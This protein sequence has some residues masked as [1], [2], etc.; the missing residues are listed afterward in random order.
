MIGRSLLLAA[1]AATLTACG[2]QS[3]AS[4]GDG[5]L[6]GTV[7]IS[8]SSPVCLAGKS[9]SKPARG[10]KLVFGANGR[11]VTA[12]T[13]ARG[14]YRVRLGGGRY[15]V[16]AGTVVTQS[17]KR[18]LRPRKVTVPGSGFAKRDFLYDTGIR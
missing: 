16:R 14:R 13:D 8:P 15:V 10:F 17:P 9:C 4:T 5:G 1:G 6:Y 18:G 2:A 11:T 7:R 3:S 12:T